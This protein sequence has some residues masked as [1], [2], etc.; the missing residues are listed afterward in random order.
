VLFNRHSNLEGTHAFLSASNYHWIN[1]EDDKLVRA[2]QT[3]QAARRGVALHNLAKE[4][5][6]LGVRLPD[7]PATINQYVNDA[8]GFKMVPE[9]VLF[10]SDNCYGTADTISFWRDKLRIHDYKSGVVKA[11][12]KQLEVYAALFCLEYGF[13]PYEIEMELRIYQNDEVRIYTPEDE[14]IVYIMDKIVTFS[15]QIDELKKDS[16]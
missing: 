15:K 12:E 7:T 8:I 13:K 10:Y 4:A 16:I 9:Q 2:F 6:R 1:Y 3:S 14:F 5:I 11:S